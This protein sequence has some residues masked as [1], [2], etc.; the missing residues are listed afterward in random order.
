M[1]GVSAL[2]REEEDLIMEVEIGVGTHPKEIP[3]A[4]V[5][6]QVGRREGG[7]DYLSGQP[8]EP[9]ASRTQGRIQILNSSD[10]IDQI[11]AR[12]GRELQ[13]T[14]TE[15]FESRLDVVQRDPVWIRQRE[16]CGS[17]PSSDPVG[18]QQQACEGLNE[19]H[20]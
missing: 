4:A 9:N 10:P 5:V 11:E 20:A 3:V 17:G 6:D 13:S 19:E 1:K 15:G 8:S 12:G 2:R 7:E 16:G 18:I 14:N